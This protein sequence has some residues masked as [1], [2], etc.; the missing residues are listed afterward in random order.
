MP[1]GRHLNSTLSNNSNSDNKESVT[2]ITV[3][4][5]WNT[6]PNTLPGHLIPLRRWLPAQDPRYITLVE[7]GYVLS[8]GGT[9]NCISDNHI[10]RLVAKLVPRGS[11]EEPC[12]IDAEDEDFTDLT[13]EEG[14]AGM[15]VDQE[16]AWHK[17]RRRERYRVG[18]ELIESVDGSMCDDM[19]STVDDLDTREELKKLCKSSGVVLLVLWENKRAALALVGTGN[20]GDTVLKRIKRIVE[21]GLDGASV[22]DFNY[23]KSQL[24][25]EI[26]TLPNDLKAGY[27]DTVIARTLATSVRNLGPLIASKVDLYMKVN[28]AAG[29]LER[30]KDT[31]VEILGAL[32]NDE[33][34]E[35]NGRAH[36]AQV[37]VRRR[38]R[39]G[40]PRGARDGGRGRGGGGGGGGRN[41]GAPGA[42]DKPWDTRD[43][44]PSDGACGHCSFLKKSPDGRH[45]RKHC[46]HRAAAIAARKAKAEEVPSG[47]GKGNLAAGEF[48]PDSLSCDDDDDEPA[49][50]DE[51]E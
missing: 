39:G 14:G 34:E 20:F 33:V 9:V 30:T 47:D 4:P 42:D 3:K 38:T 19:I 43:W 46:P 11:F 15:T 18:T 32:E 2:D 35:A 25:T 21:S 22:E 13:A 12:V 8:K 29:D 23:F 17:H 31:L 41:P 49:S 36:A 6:S 28:S 5:M 26:K 48:E 10:D 45:W 40:N 37:D 44:Q 24:N 7:F 1:K 50:G 51:A 27:P 16:T